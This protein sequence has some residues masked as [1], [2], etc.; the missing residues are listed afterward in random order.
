MSEQFC[1]F[2]CISCYCDQI[3]IMERDDLEYIHFRRKL[4]S[5]YY[6]IEINDKK[7]SKYS[8]VFEM[9]YS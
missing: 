7:M 4:L 3:V 5:Y 8:K 9:Y 2:R 1:I 6:I